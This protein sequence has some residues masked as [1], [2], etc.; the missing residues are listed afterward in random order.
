M[1]YQDILYSVEEEAALITKLHGCQL[2]D[3][4]VGR[5]LVISAKDLAG[6]KGNVLQ[7]P[8]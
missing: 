3:G 7:S 6:N 4:R 8:N 1:D 2:F 5:L